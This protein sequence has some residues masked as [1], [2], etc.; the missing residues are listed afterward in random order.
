MLV[1]VEGPAREQLQAAVAALRAEDRP[2]FL[3]DAGLAVQAAHRL[4]SR[5]LQPAVELPTAVA[6]ARRC[7]PSAFVSSFLLVRLFVFAIGPIFPMRCTE[8]RR[9]FRF[10]LINPINDCTF[11]L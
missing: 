3:A 9:V 4:C 11:E 6:T 8:S 1:M 7:A 5:S 10:R 2:A